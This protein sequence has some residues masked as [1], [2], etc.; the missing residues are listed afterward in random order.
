[1]PAVSPSAVDVGRISHE[2]QQVAKQGRIVRYP[3]QAGAMIQV[4]MTA[5]AK[6]IWPRSARLGRGCGDGGLFLH[7]MP[8]CR[9]DP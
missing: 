9:T 8:S 6:C 4:E 2:I 5:A 7:P 3:V 1:L